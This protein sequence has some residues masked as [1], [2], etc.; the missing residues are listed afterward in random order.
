M[1]DKPSSTKEILIEELDSLRHTLT[2]G[3]EFQHDIPIANM[4]NDHP[5]T[6]RSDI[7]NRCPSD[8][9]E[10]NPETLHSLN[11]KSQSVQSTLDTNNPSNF[12]QAKSVDHNLDSESGE[13]S[14]ANN[15]IDEN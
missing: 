11:T 9:E 12:S 15:S 13:P 10:T 7:D 2:D 3:P 5:T 14:S 1:S 6:L 4:V 8:Q